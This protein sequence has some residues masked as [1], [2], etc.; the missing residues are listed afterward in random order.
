MQTFTNLCHICGTNR[1]KGNIKLNNL[2]LLIS[3]FLFILF[4]QAKYQTV[5][6]QLRILN[7]LKSIWLFKL[8]PA[9]HLKGC[10]FLALNLHHLSF[11]CMNAARPR[12][13]EN[14]EFINYKWICTANCKMTNLFNFWCI[15]CW[16]VTLLMSVL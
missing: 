10:I 15:C 16:L 9:L 4:K 5:G 7:I 6:W 3:C 12:P 8:A 1:N 11:S 2:N 14:T 13:A